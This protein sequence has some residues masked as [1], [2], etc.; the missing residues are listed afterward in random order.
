M[1]RILGIDLGAVRVGLAVSDKSRTLASAYGFIQFRGH[2]DLLEKLSQIAE[3]EDVGEFVVGLPLNMD[4]SKGIQAG[5]A[6]RIAEILRNETGLPVSFI[7]ER[8]TTVEAARQIHA[9]GHKVKK[10]RIDEVAATIILQAYL[11][12]KKG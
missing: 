11:D 10:G 9:S 1:S 4:G 3:K 2:K 7:D 6:E 5:K 12:G 8:L